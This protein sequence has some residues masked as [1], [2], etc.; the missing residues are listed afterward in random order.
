MLLLYLL[1]TVLL[2]SYVKAER[3]ILQIDES[4]PLSKF[5]E[6]MKL[7]KAKEV[8][9]NVFEL[10]H[11]SR[12]PLNIESVELS[13]GKFKALIGN[14]NSSTLIK[15]SNDERVTA[16]YHDSSWSLTN[17]PLESYK[18][19]ASYSNLPNVFTEFQHE[20]SD[21]FTSN[22]DTSINVYILSTGIELSGTT[23]TDN[24]VHKLMDFT[25]NPIPGGDPH[26]QGTMIA[27]LIASKEHSRLRN[28]NIIDI[29]VLDTN[30]TTSTARLLTAL[31]RVER[32]IKHDLDQRPSMIFVPLAVSPNDQ[33]L[34]KA[35]RLIGDEIPTVYAKSTPVGDQV[36]ATLNS[37]MLAN[38]LAHYLASGN[39][40]AAASGWLDSQIN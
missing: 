29:R 37:V 35:L 26:G 5:I 27:E 31:S 10:F 11:D 40:P 9:W 21:F 33:P 3:I 13:G 8:G 36:L 28:A 7:P 19:W 14:F 23:L 30:G 1:P 38:S 22:F 15:L 12:L 34:D 2:C 20:N 39:T 18:E 16:M 17:T 32:H 24:S 4:V 25:T 6:D